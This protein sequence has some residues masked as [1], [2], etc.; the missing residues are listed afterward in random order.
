M[1]KH[2]K[3]DGKLLQVNKRFSNLKMKQQEKISAWMY[4]AYKRQAEQGLGDDEALMYVFDKIEKADIWIPDYEIY[5]RYRTK[6]TKFKKRYESELVDAE[7]DRAAGYWIE[8]DK[9][10]VKLEDSALL[11]KITTFINGHNTCAL[12]TASSDMVR[13]TPIEYNYVDGTFY[14]FSEGGLKFQG[15][16]KNKNVG[17]AIYEPYG[18]FG[19]LKSL[20]VEGTASL[21][22]PFCDEYLKLLEYKKLS[23]ETMKKLQQPMHLIKIVPKSFDFLDSDLKKEG[24]GSRQHYER[25]NGD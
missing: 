21:I 6:K 15:L 12:A 3:V 24:F 8:K 10:A 9:A 25:S 22:E 2:V 5:N 4:E 7:Y 13:C 11:E 16:K 19:Q 18:G 1:S 23:E 14:L 17:L 20:Q